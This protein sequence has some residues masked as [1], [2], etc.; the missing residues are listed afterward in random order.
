MKN[1]IVLLLI[2]FLVAPPVVLCSMSQDTV[3]ETDTTEIAVHSIENEYDTQYATVFPILVDEISAILIIS[4]ILALFFVILALL[5]F[6]SK[7]LNEI[8]K[9]SQQLS[10]KNEKTVERT[11]K[12]SL[13]ERKLT[14]NR[15]LLFSVLK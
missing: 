1:K 4:L 9:A 10:I 14:S 8:K 5:Y 15:R 2:Y 13:R 6:Y 3:Y 7:K 11:L 12:Q